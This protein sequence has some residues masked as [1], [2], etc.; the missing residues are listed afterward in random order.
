VDGVLNNHRSVISMIF[1]LFKNK[2]SWQ[3]KDSNVRIAAINEQLN[4]AN[5]EDKAILYSLLNEDK[6]ELVRR[7]VLLKLN[8]F[9]DYF[10]ALNTNDNAA[11]KSFSAAQVQ[12]ILHGNHKIT[13]TDDQ[14]HNFLNKVIS[15]QS[16]DYSLLNNWLEHESSPE[17]IVSLFKVLVLKRNVSQFFLQIFTKKQS[18][19]IQKHLLT[20]ELEQLNESALLTKLSKKAVND[21][22]LQLI[23]TCL[24]KQIE[25]QEKPKKLLKQNQLLLAKLMA[26]KDSADYS[27]YL[28]KKAALLAEWQHNLPDMV[29]LSDEDQ[30]T[31]LN[32]HT[33]IISQLTQLFAPKEEIYQQAKI[34][35]QLLSDK[36]N[37]EVDFNKAITDFNQTIITAVF[38]G[39]SIE[40]KCIEGNNIED[41]TIDQQTFISQLSQLTEK[42]N[43]SILNETEQAKFLQQIEQLAKRLTQLPE[44]AQSVSEA[45]YLISKISQLALPQTLTD[46]NDRQQTYHDWLK[47][48]KIVDRK[49]CG[50]LPQSIK[51]AHYEITQLWRKGLLPLQQEQ[52]QLF[53]QTK[54]KLIDLKRLL[55]NGKYKVCFGLFKGVSQ[56]IILLSIAQQQQLQRDFDN[57]SEKMT[58]I[59]D[60][61][62]YIATP[63]KQELLTEI[64]T[65][66]TTPLD[67]PNDQ[68]DKVKQF[69][70]VWNSLGHAEETLDKELNE[71]FNLA[72]EQAF[73][74]CRL[75]Y[76]EQEKLRA[77]HLITRN[78][79]L[80]QAKNLAET[81]KITNDEN[82][83]IDIK[84][85]DGQ[86][87]K[88]QQRWQQAG[89]VDRQQ[90][91]KLFIQYKNFI[92]PIKK[93]IKN[94]YDA[95]GLSKQAL[96]VK[97]EQQLANEDI[98]QAIENIKKLQRQWRDI[99]FAGSHQESKLWQ[100]FRGI[101]DQV[102]AKREQAKSE[103]QAE[104]D[105]LAADFNQTLLNIKESIVD[106]SA[107]SDSNSLTTAKVKADELL[108]QVLTHKP[109]LKAVVSA[110]EHFIKQTSQQI[111][112]IIVEEQKQS[113]QS[114]F[115]LLE[116]FAHGQIEL[117]ADDIVHEIEY[118]QLTSFWQKRIIEQCSLSTQVNALANA[119][120]RADQTL[121]L[122]ILGR[123]DSPVEFSQPRMAVQVSLMQEQMQ[124]GGNLDL[125][126]RFVDWLRLGKLVS[127]DVA[128]LTRIKKIFI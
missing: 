41:E 100:K 46:L 21:E 65:L 26:L 17:L 11:V 121:A 39:K 95:N 109:V 103:Q 53:A 49:A 35:E 91:Q 110:I 112:Q 19:V 69:R 25:Q 106:T 76:G 108:S 4:S 122:E 90:Y 88:L 27:I 102:F 119:E 116:K 89:E 48:W 52:K 37:A 120:L 28:V 24:A 72:C 57:V 58:E 86:L 29:Y 94:F 32:K 8:S 5:N 23:N 20:L 74:P 96:I 45:T 10:T 60:W 36:K 44:I 9:D 31:L 78:K 128:L 7:A 14:K 118:Q 66:V 51:D 82:A 38:E 113:W 117:S 93:C 84:N 92:Q 81:L 1:N 123:V 15:N 73:A 30:Q 64:T 43:N 33:K 40:G 62:H 22:V 98:Y 97:A 55:A 127:E 71:K 83:S 54:K 67:N 42:V 77:Q 79:V 56:A 63:R 101:N 68:A 75:F 114:L 12:D 13:L 85:L 16:V 80:E 124:S 99:A 59:S 50:I 126:Q 104:L 111:K 3:H 125:S 115:S 34:T 61:E 6:N 87:N 70:K 105:N 107:G 18:E 47:D 2:N